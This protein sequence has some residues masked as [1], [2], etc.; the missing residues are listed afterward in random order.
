[1]AFIEQL[2]LLQRL[3]LLI[4]RKGTGSAKELSTKLNMCRSSVFNYLDILRA[5][6]TEIEY[7]EER[8]S[9]V[10]MDN[11]RPY[12]PIISRQQGENLQGGKTFFDYF[13][14]S[15]E[16]LD[17]PLSPLYHVK[18]QEETLYTGNRASVW[19]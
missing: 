8:N 9:Y 11:R 4:A 7:C 19:L 1:M 10:Y 17:S 16:I 6:D 3:D 2:K 14:T 18:R 15:P 12:L 13:S 5:F